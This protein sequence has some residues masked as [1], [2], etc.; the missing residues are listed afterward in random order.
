MP[1][2]TWLLSLIIWLIVLGVI[3]YLLR[4]AI[5]T[6]CPDPIRAVANVILVVVVVLILIYMLIGI[7]PPLHPYRHAF[8]FWRSSGVPFAG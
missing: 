8:L 6:A 4:W 7:L 1:D 5:N 3:F 2:L